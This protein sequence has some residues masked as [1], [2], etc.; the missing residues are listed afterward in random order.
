MLHARL[1]HLPVIDS[2]PTRIADQVG[3]SGLVD[4]LDQEALRFR[5]A[6]GKGF[7]LPSRSFTSRAADLDEPTQA[8]IDSLGISSGNFSSTSRAI[9][10]SRSLFQPIS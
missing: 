10:G 4:Y 7:Q 8:W 1:F 3:H 5:S 9:R 6:F 2:I